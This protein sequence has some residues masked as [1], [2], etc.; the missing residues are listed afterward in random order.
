MRPERWLGAR[1]QAEKARR[2]GA[3]II[4]LVAD[5]LGGSGPLF[6]QELGVTSIRLRRVLPSA[7]PTWQDTVRDVA[8]RA[9]GAAACLT[10]TVRRYA[11]A[12][13]AGGPLRRGVMSGGV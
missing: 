3:Q 11:L 9:A 1:D 6:V 10:G 4:Q 5:D 12:C 8:V 2:F 7:A 13:I